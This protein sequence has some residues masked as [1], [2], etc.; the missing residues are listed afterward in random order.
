M[1][2]IFIKEGNEWEYK[3]DKGPYP[4]TFIHIVGLRLGPF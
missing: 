1:R 2:N 4:V 3:R